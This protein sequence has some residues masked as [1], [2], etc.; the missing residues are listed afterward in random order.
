MAADAAHVATLASAGGAALRATGQLAIELSAG[1][2]LACLY[3]RARRS[4]CFP[5][6]AM[7][8]DIARALKACTVD[9]S[10][11]QWGSIEQ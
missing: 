10:V 1:Q 8:W 11:A 9:K 3:R 6:G 4:Y 7:S 2:P 5:H